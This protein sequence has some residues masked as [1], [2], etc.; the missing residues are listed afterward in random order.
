MSK[1][2]GYGM[3]S[4]PIG[5]KETTMQTAIAKF[6]T[7]LLG[8]GWVLSTTGS[9]HAQYPNYPILLFVDFLP[10]P[11]SNTCG[12]TSVAMAASYLKGIRLSQEIVRDENAW[13][14]RQFKDSR[15]LE[16]NGFVT[17]FKTKGVRNPNC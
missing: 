12:Q 4:R 7:A 15:Y 3:Y 10:Q 17:Y 16:P 2:V 11:S 9:V 13:L 6:G 14:A 5:T 8:L 1:N